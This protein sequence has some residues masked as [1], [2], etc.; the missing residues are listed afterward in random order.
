MLLYSAKQS[1]FVP[2]SLKGILMKKVVRSDGHSATSVWYI[3]CFRSG[4]VPILIFDCVIAYFY[5]GWRLTDGGQGISPEYTLAVLAAV[6]GLQLF[7]F[8]VEMA[9]RTCQFVWAS[10]NTGGK[11]F[12]S[13]MIGASAFTTLFMCILHAVET[14]LTNNP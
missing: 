4:L 5:Y 10:L 3:S 6:H 14:Y 7:V 8:L 9:V 12:V 2:C 11:T 13:S 1:R